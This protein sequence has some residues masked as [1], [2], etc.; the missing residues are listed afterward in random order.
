MKQF[1]IKAYDGKGKLDKRMEVRRR[2]FEGMEKMKE[3]ILCAGGMLDNDGKMMGSLLVMEFETREQL[4]E[5]LSNEPYVVEHVW[6]QIEVEQM[7]VVIFDK[8]IIRERI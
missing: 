5:Y 2:H 4:D 7:N 3:H 6:E 1:V 8:E